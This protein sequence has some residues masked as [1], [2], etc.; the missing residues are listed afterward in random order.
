MDDKRKLVPTALEDPGF[1]SVTPIIRV[2]AVAGAAVIFVLG[3]WAWLLSRPAASSVVPVV[4]VARSAAPAVDVDSSDS[5]LA[6]PFPTVVHPSVVS[7]ALKKRI[8]LLAAT[9][10]PVKAAA[11]APPISHDVATVPRVLTST[12]VA[13]ASSRMNLE[14]PQR[15]PASVP[16]GS[17][18]TE[19]SSSSSSF[20][21]SGGAPHSSFF[22]QQGGSEVGY[23]P[24]DAPCIVRATSVIQARLVTHVDSELPGGVVKAQVITPVDC[25]DGDEAIPGGA[26]LQGTYDAGTVAGESRL[27][28][29]FTRVLFPPSE[30]HPNGRAY[31]MATQSATD[32]LGGTGLSGQVNTHAGRF[33]GQALL[34]TLL[35]AAGTALGNLGSHNGTTIGLGGASVTGQFVPPATQIRPTIYANAGD[36]VDVVLNR[37]LPM[38]P[39]R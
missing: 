19:L 33:F 26:I 22:A 17:N 35:G 31:V 30:G 11:A 4:T 25:T 36:P 39:L 6:T 18:E 20:V 13:S 5:E 23:E 14:A 38:E 2:A 3:L 28:V 12:E 24:E 7:Q 37:D 21:G 34:Y 9:A 10:A 16:E 32:A 15:P 27:L 8:P 29:V 1:R